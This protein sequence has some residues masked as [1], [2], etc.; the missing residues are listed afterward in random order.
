MN[1]LFFPAA[2]WIDNVPLTDQGR[3]PIQVARDE[4]YVELELADGTRKRYV[5]AVKRTFSIE[6]LWLPDHDH[7]TIDGNAARQKIV[8]MIGDS[9]DVHTLRF[10]ERNGEWKEYLVFCAGYT[11]TLTRRDP[12]TGSFFWD[13]Q[14]EFME[15]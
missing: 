12:S 13:I 7:D 1:N 5:K 6:W 8:E 3:A 4:R 10:Y 2:V 15:S 9:G 14:I 11:E